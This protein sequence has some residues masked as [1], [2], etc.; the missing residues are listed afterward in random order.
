MWTVRDWRAGVSHTEGCSATSGSSGLLPGSSA[1]RDRVSCRPRHGSPGS[2]ALAEF[3]HFQRNEVVENL[4]K[5]ALELRVEPLPGLAGVDIRFQGVDFH[6]DVLTRL[7]LPV[8]D[9]LSEVVKLLGS[10][11]LGQEPGALALVLPG[12]G[13]IDLIDDVEQ[14]LGV[15][16][17]EGRVARRLVADDAV[18]LGFEFP[19]ERL[20]FALE[21]GRCR[22]R[23]R[24]LDRRRS[25]TR[26]PGGA[27][28]R[29]RWTSGWIGGMSASSESVLDHWR[30]SLGSEAGSRRLRRGEHVAAR[31]DFDHG[32]YGRVKRPSC[33]S[34][35]GAARFNSCPKRSPRPGSSC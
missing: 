32:F 17:L 35:P 20:V 15:F 4:R 34:G 21:G 13:P 7:G 18:D 9:R 23:G 3:G 33:R 11:Q 26:L 19:I 16:V 14:V 24:F 8:P 29:P 5:L 10:I 27:G 25:R 22:F 30:R 28:R 1:G 31:A 12:Q 2:G 6:A